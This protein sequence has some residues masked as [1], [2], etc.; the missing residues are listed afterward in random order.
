MKFRGGGATRKTGSCCGL[1]LC[2]NFKITCLEASGEK[3]LRHSELDSES[4]NADKD[5]LRLGGR[6]DES[7]KIIP[8]SF[9]HPELVSESLN[10]STDS[11]SEAGMTGTESN[12]LHRKVRSDEGSRTPCT[13]F[14]HS[15]GSQS[16][17][18][19]VNLIRHLWQ[20]KSR[21]AAF[22]MAE[23]LITLGI[24]GI[25]AAMTLPALIQRKQEKVTVTRLKKVYSILSQAYDRLF[26]ENGSDAT[27]WGLGDMY[28]QE[29]HEILANKFLPYLNV[30]QNCVG[31][32]STYVAKHCT[33]IYNY[34]PSYSSVRLIDGVTVIFRSWY[35]DCRMNLGNEPHLKN[36]CGEILVDINGTGRPDLPGN[37]IFT[38]YLTK[39]GIYPMGTE[40]D[41][42]NSFKEKC[43]KDIEWGAS[44]GNMQN[45]MGCTAWV[46]YK[47]NQEYLRCS[48]LDWNG[49]NKC[50]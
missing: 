21:K 6:S 41:T 28:E 50:R 40:F 16:L 36:V 11:G 43:N 13:T 29:S 14:R 15:D 17:S 12:I 3:F 22:T 7:G 19:P 45:G 8:S 9:R 2:H 47:E 48:D 49:K 30:I 31:K 38:F 23:V 46:L 20:Q 37:D 24:I 42:R 4:I 39:N 26:Y 27:G 10:T 33:K 1:D 35:G 18:M 25:I 34:S 44:V 32:D 5:R